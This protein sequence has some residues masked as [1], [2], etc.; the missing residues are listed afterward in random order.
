M[1]APFTSNDASVETPVV[2]IPTDPNIDDTSKASRLDLGVEVP[3]PI[4]E[5]AATIFQRRRL[6][7]HLQLYQ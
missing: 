6:V 1:V 3:I 4:E 5:P 7:Q 2:L